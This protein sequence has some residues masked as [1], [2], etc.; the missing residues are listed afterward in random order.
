MPV[1]SLAVD[2]LSSLLGVL[3]HRDRIRL[4]EELRD[5]EHDVKSLSQA[6]D[7][8][9]PRVSQHL[10]QLRAHHLVQI[11]RE[12]RRVHYRLANPRVAIWLVEGLDFI[13]ADLRHSQKILDAV[14][15][16]RS[17]WSEGDEGSEE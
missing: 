17:S 2:E 9:Q 3:S 10:A 11:R 1:R 16:T 13:E 14:A 8:A 12:G 7:I 15:E 6:L 5:G 4:V